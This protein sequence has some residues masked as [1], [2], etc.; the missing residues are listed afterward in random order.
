MIE[1]I[2]FSDKIDMKEK[3]EKIREYANKIYD[4]WYDEIDNENRDLIDS[5]YNTPISEYVRWL[6]SD[7]E[8]VLKKDFD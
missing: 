1:K 6:L 5:A 8:E 4:I 2:P 7:I 3:L